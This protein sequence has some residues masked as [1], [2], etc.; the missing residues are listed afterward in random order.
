MSKHQI[1]P[2]I[3]EKADQASMV[4]ADSEV[5]KVFQNLNL[6]GYF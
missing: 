1:H 2:I 3:C 5:R 4:L 6:H